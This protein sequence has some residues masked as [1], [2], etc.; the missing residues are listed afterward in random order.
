M[1]LFLDPDKLTKRQVAAL[2]GIAYSTVGR[3]TRE[4]KLKPHYETAERFAESVF[5]KR[6][7]LPAPTAKAPKAPVSKLLTRP[8]T[9]GNL[10]EVP[11]SPERT[12]SRDLRTW[13]ERYRDGDE[14]DS[15]GNTIDGANDQYKSTG[16]SLLGPAIPAERGPKPDVQSHMSAALLASNDHLGN[17]IVGPVRMNCVPNF[18]DVA[19][20]T[21]GHTRSGTTLAPGLSQETYDKMFNDWRRSGGGRSMAEQELSIRRSKQAIGAAFPKG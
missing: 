19:F 13:A 4:G 20:K 10:P 14:T 18:V 7:E 12:E 17:P 1:T 5:F 9:T 16:A 11:A 6:S 21:E 2:L 8:A 15:C 3:W